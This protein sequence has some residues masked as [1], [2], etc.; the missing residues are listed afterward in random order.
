MSTSTP[1]VPSIFS[2]NGQ[3]LSEEAK[4]DVPSEALAARVATNSTLNDIGEVETTKSILYFVGGIALSV[5]G[6]TLS[7][8]MIASVVFLCLSLGE[9]VILPTAIF[10]TLVV[11]SSTTF[12]IGLTGLFLVMGFAHTSWTGMDCGGCGG[13]GAGIAAVIIL[14]LIVIIGAVAPAICGIWLLCLAC[15]HLCNRRDR[16][17]E[18]Q[19]QWLMKKMNPDL[20]WRDPDAYVIAY[21][22]LVKGLEPE[23]IQGIRWNQVDD[24]GV[25]I[26]IK[27]ENGIQRKI[28]C[29][30][31]NLLEQYKKFRSSK[32]GK[33][34]VFPAERFSKSYYNFIRWMRKEY[35]NIPLTIKHI[36][37]NFKKYEM[38]VVNFSTIPILGD[39]PK[40]GG[41]SFDE[42]CRNGDLT[43]RIQDPFAFVIFIL[44]LSYEFSVEEIEN[45]KVS[46]IDLDR[47]RILI[48]SSRKIIILSSTHKK[49]L[50][51]EWK[52]GLFTGLAFPKKKL[53]KNLA[54]LTKFLRING[55]T[56]N[57]HLHG[58]YTYEM[59]GW[60]DSI[61]SKTRQ[62]DVDF[63]FLQSDSTQS[64]S[65]QSGSNQS[66]PS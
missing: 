20:L 59:D 30:L 4:S 35:P 64:D 42:L 14:V 33:D 55:F 6:V 62:F 19:C 8:A 40:D 10:I 5:L 54:T 13:E 23:V 63:S 7:L 21:L 47:G 12:V 52:F 25:W 26:T 58:S 32:E 49:I 11:V 41:C 60:S 39:E 38:E 18:R 3:S 22:T 27:N 53:Q 56:E 37:D 43:I 2:L 34:L 9:L 66:G 50:N 31:G 17:Y 48:S 45:L 46:D 24:D 44:I 29:D 36:R 1:T 16:I 61:A 28:E 51:R 15:G 65:T 57:S